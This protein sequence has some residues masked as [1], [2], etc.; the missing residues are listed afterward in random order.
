VVK[1][2][3]PEVV[4]LLH[5]L[6]IRDVAEGTVQ[7]ARIKQAALAGLP[8]LRWHLVGHLQR[9]K[10]RRVVESFASLHSLDSLRLAVAIEEEIVRLRAGPAGAG[11]ERPLPVLYLEVNVSGESRKGG[12]AAAEAR[13]FLAEIRRLP[14]VAS[15]IAGLMTMAPEGPDPEDVRPVFRALRELRDGL[16]ADG[17]LPPGAGLSMGMSG[18]YRVAVEEGA[19]VVRVG[20]RLFAGLPSASLQAEG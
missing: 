11:D 16:I 8:G 5:A 13:R 10:A 6:G 3:G 4:K 19:T 7:Q 15:R 9:N 14:G 2:V 18:D 20:T 1:S 12:V 17:L